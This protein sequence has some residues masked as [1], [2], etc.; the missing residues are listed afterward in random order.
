MAWSGYREEEDAC[1][2]LANGLYD[3]VYGMLGTID[4]K[5]FNQA[6][7]RKWIWE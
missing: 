4:L 2:E 5:V 1:G 6:L 7:L 3:E